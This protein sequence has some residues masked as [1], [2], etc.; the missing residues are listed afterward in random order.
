MTDGM[1]L[2]LFVKDD[3][4]A[5]ADLFNVIHGLEGSPRGYD[6]PFLRDMLG[7]PGLDVEQNCMLAVQ[8]EDL[9]G[10]AMVV[11]ELPIQRIVLE[12]GVHPEHRRGGVGSRLLEWGIA[13]GRELGAQRAHTSV[14][15]AAHEAWAFLER[16]GYTPL[17][18]YWEVRWE[19]TEIACD[20]P[21]GVSLRA[22]EDGDAALLADVQNA[23]FASQW[24]YSP[25]TAEQVTY[26]AHMERSSPEGILFLMLDAD[27]RAGGQPRG[28]H[29][30]GGRAPGAPGAGAGQD[31]RHRGDLPHAPA[32]RASGGAER[33]QRQYARPGALPFAGLPEGGGRPVVRAQPR[34]GLTGPR[35]LTVSSVNTPAEMTTFMASSKLR[36]VSITWSRR[37]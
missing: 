7:Q 19:G 28:D 29:L 16:H 37:T 13:R 30:D 20:L 18:H 6:A 2:R 25:N 23:A 11:P 17:R 32:G 35:L 22:F 14:G 10:Y 12:S 9:V 34:Q 4:P 24:G 15:E 1:E 3:V 5:L 21:E 8:G 31:H 33:G 27:G 26:K 36:A